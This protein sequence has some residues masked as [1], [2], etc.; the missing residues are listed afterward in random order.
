MPKVLFIAA[1]RPNRS[2]SHRFIFE[3]YFSYLEYNGFEC[4]LS[5]FIS[6][7]DDT[8][9]YREGFL[10]RKS[11]ILLKAFFIRMKDAF[12]Y[13]KYDIVFVQREAIMLVSTF[14]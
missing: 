4:E 8:Y 2:P 13:S 3:Q 7:L 12:R 14:F 10:L 11:F 6:Q 9:F 1:H 5:Y